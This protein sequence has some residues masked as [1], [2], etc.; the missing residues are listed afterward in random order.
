[1][2]FPDV[3]LRLSQ[4]QG[5]PEPSSSARP[6]F[7]AVLPDG[8][9]DEPDDAA[10]RH[11]SLLAVD[12]IDGSSA[13]NRQ[14]FIPDGDVTKAVKIPANGNGLASNWEAFFTP[15][16]GIMEAIPHGVGTAGSIVA[17]YTGLSNGFALAMLFDSTLN[18]DDWTSS[19]S[20][21]RGTVGVASG[22]DSPLYSG[23]F[24]KSV[25]TCD[26]RSEILCIT[27]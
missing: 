3:I 2:V 7:T 16:V 4:E 14:A 15:S 19:T 8:I 11:E 22:G 13:A 23:R 27:Y 12:G 20:S 1:M 26:T 18:C 10:L 21:T 5:A 9:Q 6:R 24:Q 25:E 17:H